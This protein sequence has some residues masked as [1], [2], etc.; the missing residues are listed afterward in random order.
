[1]TNSINYDTVFCLQNS[2]LFGSNPNKGEANEAPSKR[3]RT[4][5]SQAE[6]DGQSALE[7]RLHEDASG[8]ERAQ[9]RH[10]RCG[11]GNRG[12]GNSVFP[13]IRVPGHR[14]APRGEGGQEK[15]RQPHP[16]PRRVQRHPWH[17][18]EAELP[19]V[20]PPGAK[21]DPG[22]P[23]RP[24]PRGQPLAPACCESR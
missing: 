14:D 12:V 2:V 15:G 13:G 4:E 20:C 10:R 24:P 19:P 17:P 8:H 11:R 6:A 18:L 23:A 5:K 16:G 9:N 22:S 3:A 7:V 1:M 21:P